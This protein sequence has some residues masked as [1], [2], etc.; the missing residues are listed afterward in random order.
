[1]FPTALAAIPLLVISL[2]IAPANGV[3]QGN[4]IS[5]GEDTITIQDADG[6][7]ETF[8]VALSGPTSATIPAGGG[9][10]T[11]TITD[12]DAATLSINDV[13]V[14]EADAGPVTATFTVTLSAASSQTVTVDFAT[15]DGTA[16]AAT[17]Y[18]ANSGQLTFLPNS[19]LTRTV[20]VVVNGDQI[21]EANQRLVEFDL[22][23]LHRLQ[24]RLGGDV[25]DEAELVDVGRDL[26]VV[27][28][29]QRADDVV[30]QPLQLLG[31]DGG[32]LEVG[33]IGSI[34]FAPLGIIGPIRW[35]GLCA[36]IH[37]AASFANSRRGSFSTS[38]PTCFRA[39]FSS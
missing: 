25:V 32:S 38:S 13:T 11:G 22:A 29:L 33:S 27:D 4:V 3:H 37:S 39:R 24:E 28:R 31:R 10:G 16:M 35:G 2:L 23:P 14:T 36:V 1:M 6:M 18:V 8:T 20:T 15:T 9:T 34:R 19:P 26:R 5:V 12:D 30:A 17:D 7:N 21:D